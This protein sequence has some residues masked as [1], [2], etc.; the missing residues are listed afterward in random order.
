MRS[1]SQKLVSAQDCM[2]GKCCGNLRN[3]VNSQLQHV[4]LTGART[5]KL[6]VSGFH[7]RLFLRIMT[8][9]LGII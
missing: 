6:I 5:P 9:P 8:Q 7:T 3:V 4:C 1:E 2:L